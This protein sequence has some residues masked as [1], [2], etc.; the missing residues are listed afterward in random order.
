MAMKP[1]LSVRLAAAA[2]MALAV[3]ACGR[4]ESYRY[5]LTLAV[6]TPSGVKRA[7]SV[8]EVLLL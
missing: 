8:A 7:S 3:S 5:K 4:S 1:G 2:L 6:N